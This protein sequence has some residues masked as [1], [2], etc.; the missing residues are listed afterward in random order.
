MKAKMRNAGS[1]ESLGKTEFGFSILPN[2]KVVA[3]IEQS[4]VAMEIIMS[5]ETAARVA[6][7]LMA[8]AKQ[9]HYRAS[10]A[11]SIH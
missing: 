11:G 3:K 5:A 2:G 9:A 8:T 10:L 6:N 1:I 7:L 4:G